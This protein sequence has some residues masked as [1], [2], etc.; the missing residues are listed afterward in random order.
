M[1]SYK[2]P[3]ISGFNPDPSICRVGEDYYL[4]TSTFE[5]FP[6]VPVYHSKDLINWTK[7]GHC[8]T[9]KSQ[10]DL[11][12]CPPSLGIWAPTLRYHKGL[13]FMITT[14]FNPASGGFQKF[15]VTTTNPA[16]EWSDPIYVDQPG[17]DPSLFFD[18]DGKVYITSN[19]AFNEGMPNGI[20]QAEIDIQ[21]GKLL[22]ENKLVWEGAGGIYP[23]GPHL[24]KINDTYY[25]LIS[26][27]GS[28]TG[29]YITIA[30]SD[31]PWGPWEVCPGKIILTHKDR[32]AQGHEIQGTGHGDIIQAHDGSWWMVFLAFRHTDQFFYH[33]GRETF[34]SP[35]EWDE[36]GWP[37]I[38]NLNHVDGTVSIEMTA[39]T[40]PLIP[41][42]Q[43]PARDDFDSNKLS[44]E[45]NT[46]R[47]LDDAAW[48]LTEKRGFLA[49]FG[50]DV[51]INDVA[52]PSMLC[53]RQQ[54]FDCEVKTVLEFDPV[55]DG[56]E[57]GLM[58][59]YNNEHH[60]EIVLTQIKGQRKVIV[61]RSIGDLSA[62][63][64]EKLFSGSQ[65]Y[66]S[67]RA[68]RLM[69]ELC[70][71]ESDNSFDVLATGRTR[72]LSTEVTRC[73]FTG[74]YF[75]LY[76][77]GNGKTCVNPAYFDWFDYREKEPTIGHQKLC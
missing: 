59:F 52:A 64:A 44:L 72:Y 28:Q 1:Q 45:W 20:Y 67:I 26:E 68:N 9:R 48:S 76:A 46:L 42:K 4:V 30:K 71:G 14:N 63:V 49:L 69:Y 21:T 31:S 23:E 17:I 5:Y 43:V 41:V 77:S 18:D 70:C 54:H 74:V 29:H 13:F 62:I 35:V 38:K 65:V 50:K 12:G 39:N 40:L 33:L 75:G 47:N 22:T 32:N 10:L 55:N 37:M 73:S 25:M 2:N 3:I 66:L 27:G 24:Y 51:T 58:V 11:D 53:R 56:E 34:I 15:Y 60:Y 61:R 19:S 6:G 7:V 16:G 57:A 36:N 8:L